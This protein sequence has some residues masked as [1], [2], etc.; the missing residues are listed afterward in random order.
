MGWAWQI[1]M[2]ELCEFP[3]CTWGTE[4]DAFIIIIIEIGDETEEKILIRPFLKNLV[5]LSKLQP[6]LRLKYRYILEL[7]SFRFII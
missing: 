5:C 4:C 3:D 7:S 6:F 1:P 2:F